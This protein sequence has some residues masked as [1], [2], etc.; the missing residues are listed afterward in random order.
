MEPEHQI[1]SP[2]PGQD[3]LRVFLA[4]RDVP[5]PACGY[6]LRDL[7]GSRCPEC[8]DDLVL[9]VGLPEPKQA[10]LIA[11]L[12]GL[13]AGAGMSG[14]LIGYAAIVTLFRGIRPPPGAFMVLTIGGFIMEGVPLFLWLWYWGGIRRLP[15]PAKYLLVAGCW[16][17]TALNLLVFSLFVR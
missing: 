17:L 3:F 2:P 7:E 4:S 5:C 15:Q 10:A 6:N 14:L 16:T 9:Q 13:A 12:I 8:G 11:G 1:D